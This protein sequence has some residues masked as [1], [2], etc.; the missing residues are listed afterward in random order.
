M[1][2]ASTLDHLVVRADTLEAGA[3]YVREALGVELEAGGTHERM[4]THNLLLSLGD[5]RYLEVIAINPAALTPSRPRWFGLD[6]RPAGEPPR[7]IAWVARTSD[8]RG[9]AST[10]A[11]ELGPVHEMSRDNLS[12]L[13]TIRPDGRQPGGGVA[14]ALIEWPPGIHPASRLRRAGC[15]LEALEVYT[16]DPNQLTRLFQDLAL[17]GAPHIHRLPA[18]SEAYLVAH[19]RTP[20]GLRTLSGAPRE[21]YF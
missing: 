18:G 4:G 1:V 16:P 5:A 10:R 8:I 20:Q 21:V 3:A 13:L 2:L 19:V 9:L 17:E 12:W 15:S 7:L 14:P 11:A 6:E